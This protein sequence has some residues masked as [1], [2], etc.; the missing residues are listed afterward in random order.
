VKVCHFADKSKGAAGF[1]RTGISPYNGLASTFLSLWPLSFLT[2]AS[3]A[4]AV[5]CDAFGLGTLIYY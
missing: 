4:L 2:V 1:H 3:Q 5:L